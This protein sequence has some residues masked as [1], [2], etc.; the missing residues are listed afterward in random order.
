MTA[1]SK[2]GFQPPPREPSDIDSYR[3]YNNNQLLAVRNIFFNDTR[4]RIPDKKSMDKIYDERNRNRRIT[5]YV[6]K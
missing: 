6:Y 2:V 5:D 4:F 3:E 1:G